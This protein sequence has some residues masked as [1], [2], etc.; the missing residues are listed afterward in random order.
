MFDSS[1]TPPDGY[2]IDLYVWRGKFDD[3]AT[4]VSRLPELIELLARLG[5]ECPDGILLS[6][7]RPH[8]I[9]FTPVGPNVPM[10]L[11]EIAELVAELHRNGEAPVSPFAYWWKDGCLTQVSQLDQGGIVSFGAPPAFVD[12]IGRVIGW[13]RAG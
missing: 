8:E 6:M 9:A 10:D 11:F 4:G 1:L 13:R 12:V 3:L 7:P 5:T 2:E